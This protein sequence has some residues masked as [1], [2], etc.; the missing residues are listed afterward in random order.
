VFAHIDQLV[1]DLDA[2]AAGKLLSNAKWQ[3]RDDYVGAALISLAT[4]K[5]PRRIAAEVGDEVSPTRRDAARRFIA[6]HFFA[7]DANHYV[8]LGSRRTAPADLVR[9]NYQRIVALV[10]PDSSPVG[11]PLDAAARVNK[12]YA[13]LSETELRDAYDRTLPGDTST[14]V[15]LTST[16]GVKSSTV[17]KVPESTWQRITRLVP[18][19]GFRKGLIALGVGLLFLCSL[20]LYQLMSTENH[21]A[22]V[23][24]RP[25]LS[26]SAEVGSS[27]PGEMAT[28][29]ARLDTQV[30]VPAISVAPIAA[31]PPAPSAV[32]TSFATPLK[33]T[34]EL[35]RNFA[36]KS[37]TTSLTPPNDASPRAATSVSRTTTESTSASAD[38]SG[39]E[40]RRSQDASA[41]NATKPNDG[42][43][44]TQS[45]AVQTT[46]NARE[47]RSSADVDALLAQFAS[48]FEAGSLPAM[49]QSFSSNMSGRNAVLAEYERVFQSTKQRSIHFSRMRQNPLSPERVM[50]SGIATVAT[51][52]LENRLVRQRVFLEIEVAREGSN[53]RISRIA[54]YEQP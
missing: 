3:P 34:T 39:V 4:A 19:L 8:V 36:D 49:K 20:G 26:Q 7:F 52:D 44:A 11:F 48:A 42:V 29:A 41:T 28:S 12:A 43:I 35:R 15:A 51:V 2:Y 32:Q 6:S 21:V 40:V 13:T 50:T 31:A 38:Q 16:E 53:A 17:R 27:A 45:P 24:A 18:V 47:E 5:V 37:V 23:E 10:H 14:A 25:R 54:N 30:D 33:L 46:P 1:T 9:K 22:L